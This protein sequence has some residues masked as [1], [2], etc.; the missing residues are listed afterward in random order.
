MLRMK[1]MIYLHL[2]LKLQ[3]RS[4]ILTYLTIH[5]KVEW[6]KLELSFNMVQMQALVFKVSKNGYIGIGY[7]MQMSNTDYL[8]GIS[9]RTAFDNTNNN[10]IIHQTS[11][12]FTQRFGTFNW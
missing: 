7:S 1:S 12:E 10:D 4:T 3:S 5:S 11:I 2:L 6:I 8:D 9:W